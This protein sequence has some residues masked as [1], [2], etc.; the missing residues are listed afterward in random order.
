MSRVG[1]FFR[2]IGMTREERQ[3]EDEINRDVKVRMGKSRIK[4]HIAIQQ[5]MDVRLQELGRQALAL[6]D[7]GR[8][9]QIARQLLWTRAD[10]ERW[11]RYVLSMDVLEARRE[12]V[13]ASVSLM[14]SVKAM[15]ESMID[16][17]GPQQAAELQRQLQVGLARAESLDERMSI[18]MEMMDS[19]LE[20]GTP[21]DSEALSDVEKVMRDQNAQSETSAYDKEIEDGLRKIRSEL[22][23]PNSK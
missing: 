11:Q 12:Q 6:N 10:M 7:E 22:K 4:R 1:D 3:E 20:D 2:R 16:L 9:R 23:N 15:S 5:K 13:K 18:M 8:F 14:G 17:S 19:T 21:D